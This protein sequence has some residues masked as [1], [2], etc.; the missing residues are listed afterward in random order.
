MSYSV[1]NEKL[2]ATDEIEVGIR[3]VHELSLL[4]PTDPFLASASNKRVR[5]NPAPL[6][7]RSL[8]NIETL[9]QRQPI[10]TIPFHEHPI[11]PIQVSSTLLIIQIHRYLFAI[12]SRNNELL[13]LK[14]FSYYLRRPLEL[15]LLYLRMLSR[16]MIIFILLLVDEGT[17]EHEPQSVL[18]I[19]LVQHRLD[20]AD[21]AIVNFYEVEIFGVQ[22][23]DYNSGPIV[24]CDVHG[25]EILKAIKFRNQ[26]AVVLTGCQY[27]LPFIL[28]VMVRQ[29]EEIIFQNLQSEGFGVV[30]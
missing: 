3:P 25:Y 18:L 15:D 1:G 23:L 5:N 6:H 17:A 20:F 26:Q 7:R 30:V 8:D 10:S 9:T 16:F 19:L 2:S 21:V 13:A 28:P 27:R 4:M 24:L 29:V 12:M 22:I 11:P 14:I